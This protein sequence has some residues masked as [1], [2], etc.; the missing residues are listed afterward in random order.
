MKQVLSIILLL[1]IALSFTAFQCSSTELTSAKLYIQQK[2]Y[3]KAIESL[4]KEVEKNPKSDEGYYLLGFILGEQGD[5]EGMLENY[6]KSAEI[7]NKF[8]K[9]IAESRKYHWAD[10]FNK[11]VQLFN[12]GAQAGDTDSAKVI[13]QKSI[14]KFKDAIAAEPDS[15]DT[16][17]NL[18]YAYLNIG[19]RE[20]AIEPYLKVIEL[21]G[22]AGAYAQVGEMYLQLGLV[23][24]EEGK[25][26]EATEKFNSAIKLLEEGRKMHP[27]DGDILLLL[28]NSYIAA[29][30]LD[31]AKDAFKEGVIQEPENKFYRYNYGSLL[32]NAEEYEAAAVQLEKAVEID[33]NYDNALYN[34]AVTYVKWGAEMREQMEEKEVANEEYKA[35]FEAALPLLEKYLELKENESVVWDLLGKVYANLGMAEK[36][37]EAFEKA[38]L[39]K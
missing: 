9:N 18:A 38:D 15:S 21:T 5:I 24:K 1:S 39:Y 12:R 11:G 20:A 26:D 19:D 31:I 2:N 13:F 36:S 34:L 4:K 3:E 28:S 17:M 6:E 7:S 14:A 8:E 22:D 33:G 16:Y 30:K 23:L 32:L 29:D 35:K 10:G 27:S 25:N 37:K